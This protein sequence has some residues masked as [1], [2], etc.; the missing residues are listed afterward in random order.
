MICLVFGQSLRTQDEP[1]VTSVEADD[2]LSS[3]IDQDLEGLSSDGE[4][5]S[6]SAIV[7]DVDLSASAD[8][9]DTK[10]KKS[11]KALR[12]RKWL[13]FKKD[14]VT[15]A[16]KKAIAIVKGRSKGLFQGATKQLQDR[17]AKLDEWKK[18]GAFASKREVLEEINA[19]GLRLGRW[20]IRV[21]GDNFVIRDLNGKN[22]D[23]RYFFTPE[24]KVDI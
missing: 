5:D 13:T 19:N 20:H 12:I 18:S 14:I 7:D 16:V 1:A 8:K 17:V 22:G 3:V 21:E 4:D 10:D 15:Q 24:R 6:L 11:T 2:F 9:N 23:A